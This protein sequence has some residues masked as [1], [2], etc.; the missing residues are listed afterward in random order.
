MTVPPTPDRPRLLPVGSF[1]RSLALGI[2]CTCGPLLPLPAAANNWNQNASTEGGIDYLRLEELRSFYK[3]APDKLDRQAGTRSTSN[4]TTTLTF[5]PGPR[6]LTI[7]GVR[8]RLSHPTRTNARGEFIISKTDVV[9]LIDPVLRPAYIPQRREVKTIVIDPGHGGHDVGQQT[10]YAREADSVLSL[11]HQLAA[12]LRQR[13]YEVVL[14]R[15]DNRYLSDQQRIDCANGTPNAIFI[16]LHLNNGR[17]DYHGIETYTVAPAVPPATEQGDDTASAQDSPAAAESPTSPPAPTAAAGT[18]EAP[19]TMPGNEQDGAN[20]ALA[21]ALQSA[22]VSS[23]GAQDGGCRRARYS[24]L[25][26]VRCPAAIVELGYATHAEEGAALSTEE[27]RSIL[28]TGLANGVDAF[29]RAIKPGAKTPVTVAPPPPPP[30][31]P[32][33]VDKLGKDNGKK[34]DGTK[35][36]NKKSSSGKTIRKSKSK[37]RRSNWKRG[38][39]GKRTGRKR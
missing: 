25:S 24:L 29:A 38:G 32:V 2:L 23:S 21:Y 14:T 37:A 6:D 18:Q 4:G 26:S 15:E 7:H 34:A 33:K 19:T 36:G 8:C 28:A 1:C 16:S 20:I 27:Y 31:T 9:K 11:A 10:P 3:F 12:Q 5:G 13:G 39:S 35:G 30:P 22:L 17:S